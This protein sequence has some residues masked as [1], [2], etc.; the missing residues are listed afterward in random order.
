[1]EHRQQADGPEGGS[2]GSGIIPLSAR[3]NLKVLD[4]SF[5]EASIF[6]IKGI[7]TGLKIVF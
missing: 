5:L 4:E 3:E 2:A 7:K 6:F 1:M